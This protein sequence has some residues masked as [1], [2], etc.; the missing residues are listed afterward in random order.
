MTRRSYWA[1]RVFCLERLNHHFLTQQFEVPRSNP[2]NAEPRTAGVGDFS[3]Q[4]VD[5]I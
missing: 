4:S 3:P 5:L 2:L 1:I